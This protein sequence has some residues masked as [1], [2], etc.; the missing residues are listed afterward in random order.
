MSQEQATA[1]KSGAA[2]AAGSTGDGEVDPTEDK[3][4]SFWEHLDELRK[5][6]V[7]SVLVFFAACMVGWEVREKLLHFLTVPFVQAWKEQN[8]PG[9]PSLH[10]G[11]PAAAFVA[12]F[13]LS[14]IGGAA[15]ASPFIFYQLWSF[16]APGLYAREKRYV[17]PF[18][19]FSTILFVGGGLFGWR[20]AF[21]ISF[22]YFLSM[23]GTVGGDGVTITPTVMMGDYLDFVAQLLMG[24]GIIF[25]IPLIVLFLSI[26]GV[27]NYLQ[28]ILFGRWF[29]FVAFVLAAILT[30]PDITSQLV[31]A[32]PMCLLYVVS[33]G[34]AYVFG[35]PPTDAQRAAYKKRKEKE[36]SKG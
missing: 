1:V 29:V 24:F 31:M 22:G 27:I 17:I 33:I 20:A 30:P 28:L 23:A 6:L 21:P 12:Y 16:V 10:F 11:A 4:M 18:V 34:L 13:K 9:S 5:R 25:E 36:V 32:V 3:P 2:E 14:M 19:L 8:L 7:R 26:A 15:L 35:K